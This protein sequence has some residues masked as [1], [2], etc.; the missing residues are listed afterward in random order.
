MRHAKRTFTFSVTSNLKHQRG[1]APA[2]LIQL[3][4]FPADLRLC[5][6]MT[7]IQL[8]A[9]PADLRL[10]VENYLKAYIARTEKLRQ[11]KD[12]LASWKGIHGY[13]LQIGQD[14]LAISWDQ[15]QNFY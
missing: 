9:F 6:E 2:T 1:N 11:T 4:A 12:L 5:V 10:C 15:H 3:K 7:L 13:H 14:R 8:K